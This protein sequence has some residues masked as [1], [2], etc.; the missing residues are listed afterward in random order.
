MIEE[1]TRELAA[2]QRYASDLQA[3][4]AA[5][6]ADAPAGV[7]GTDAT[8][9]V[10]ITLRSD[11]LPESV[12]VAADWQPRLG[13]IGLGAAVGEAHLGAVQQRMT[14]WVT[15]LD[16]DG[17][18]SRVDG[19]QPA[20]QHQP[21]GPGGVPRAPGSSPLTGR[22]P[23]AGA[24]P[25]P[26]GDLVREFERVADGIAES[27]HPRVA[28]TG[29]GANSDQTVTITLSVAGQVSCTVDD[30]WADRRSGAE[31]SRALDE[32]LTAAREE[33]ARAVA[34]PDPTVA[35]DR[36]LDEVMAHLAHPERSR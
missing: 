10:R 26:L 6:Q 1:V 16:E 20:T 27:T 14:S 28:A 31:V 9:A 29:T 8:G 34:A 36:L 18:R 4:I 7:E 22:A 5:A 21:A 3:M 30:R 23:L 35:L 12:Q 2:L 32:A 17:W 13:A 11:G 33:L 15:Q 19:L 25:R 24:A